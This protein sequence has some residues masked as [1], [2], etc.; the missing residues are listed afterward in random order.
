[1]ARAARIGAFYAGSR[2]ARLKEFVHHAKTQ[3]RSQPRRR[4]TG[5]TGE[6]SPVDEKRGRPRPLPPAASLIP[7]KILEPA[8]REL[9][10][11]HGVLDAAVPEVCLQRAGIDAI[12]RELKTAGMP[13]H[14]R[15]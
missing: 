12:V 3:D 14:V 9:R 6:K 8:V 10:V 7:P 5:L 4:L 11:A 13:Q 15:M 2:R 1:M